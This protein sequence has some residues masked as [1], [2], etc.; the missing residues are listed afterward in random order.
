[1]RTREKQVIF[2]TTYD[3]YNELKEKADNV[4]L[5]ISDFI[6]TLV[7]GFEPR[8]KPPLEFYEAIKQIRAVGNNINQIARL[9]N[10]TGIVDEL[11]CRKQYDNLNQLVLEIK[12]E[13]L[14]PKK[15]E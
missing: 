15:K 10:S 8:E 2:R 4:G 5:S 7:S 6:R 1:M 11:A 14:L 9:A 3:E 12:R 13:Y